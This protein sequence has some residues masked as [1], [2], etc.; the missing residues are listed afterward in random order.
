MLAYVIIIATAHGLKLLAQFDQYHYCA[1]LIHRLQS[2]P[3]ILGNSFIGVPSCLQSG[4]INV[5]GICIG[6]SCS[7]RC[8]MV[9]QPTGPKRPNHTVVIGDL[10]EPSETSFST[11]LLNLPPMSLKEWNI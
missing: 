2:I 8:E 5:A 6:G 10:F 7:C 11:E 4:V 3:H 9:Q 1:T